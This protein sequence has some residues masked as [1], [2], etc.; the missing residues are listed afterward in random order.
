[1]PT[2]YFYLET[3]GQIFLLKKGKLWQFPTKTSEIPCRFKPVSTMPLKEG[4]VI[5]AKPLLSRHPFHW[6]HKDEVIGRSDVAPVVQKAV[7]RSLPRAASKVVI[8]EK[9]RVLMVKAARGLTKGYW[10]LPGGF[11][12]YGEHPGPSVQREALE[13]LGIRV[14]LTRLL[15]IFS[16]VFPRTGGYMIS[17]IYEGKRGPGKI[18]P[19]PEEMESY[20]WMPVKEAL[21]T[22]FNPFA[23]AGLK[24]YLSK[25]HPGRS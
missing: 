2:T 1:M 10:N 3:D 22:T 14:R 19:H 16:Q 15:G 4:K 9:G 24:A 7:N 18:R 23:K 6:M 12:G 5:F 20:S 8:V 17:F 11:V 13:E 25:R 21:R